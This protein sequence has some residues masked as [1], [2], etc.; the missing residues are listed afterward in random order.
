MVHRGRYDVTYVAVGSSMYNCTHV[1]CC[2]IRERIPCLCRIILDDDSYKEAGFTGHIRVFNVV[3]DSITRETGGV[4]CL[5][6]VCRTMI[7]FN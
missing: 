5:G 7:V 3:D 6:D 1:G 2:P 4:C